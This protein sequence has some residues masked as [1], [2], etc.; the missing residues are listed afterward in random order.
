[1]RSGPP[2]HCH[3]LSVT[4]APALVLATAD[5]SAGAAGAGGVREEP[6]RCG[7]G[8]LGLGACR[9]AHG[10]GGAAG[11][12]LLPL[13]DSARR[14][15]AAPRCFSARKYSYSPPLYC[16]PSGL[17]PALLPCLLPCLL[18]YHHFC[19][20][21]YSS[22]LLRAL[23]SQTNA[24]AMLLCP[25]PP[26]RCAAGLRP[27]QPL[28]HLLHHLHA[29]LP[30]QQGARRGGLFRGCALLALAHDG[31]AGHA[32]FTRNFQQGH[33]TLGSPAHP[34]PPTSPPAVCGGSVHQG[35]LPARLR[36]AGERRLHWRPGLL[37]RAPCDPCG[38]AS[39]QRL[40]AYVLEPRTLRLGRPNKYGVGES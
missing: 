33:W 5:G 30:R 11:A 26:A 6:H 27:A 2:S 37:F 15:W 21:S 7:A 12:P 1:M 38:R 17:R 14:L 16:A 39:V 18:Q 9:G 20:C 34:H 4:S 23:K 19:K 13:L 24:P 31:A 10:S 3:C 22:S 25:R 40:M 36:G 28:R 29:H 8:A 35:A 32:Q